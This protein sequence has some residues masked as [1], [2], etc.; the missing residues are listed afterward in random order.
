MWQSLKKAAMASFWASRAGRASA[1]T[2]RRA[3]PVL[4]DW[5]PLRSFPLVSRWDRRL[6]YIANAS[7]LLARWFSGR[8]TKRRL[9]GDGSFEAS[10]S[11]FVVLLVCLAAAFLAGGLWVTDA[12]VDWARPEG[13]REGGGDGGRGAGA[14][15]GA[16]VVG[17][18][19]KGTPLM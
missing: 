17:E 12:Y 16:G 2:G 19:V 1:E 4:I 6:V 14:R 9:S 11:V 15:A 7:M 5:T 13:G 3:N 8:R 10:L 18:L